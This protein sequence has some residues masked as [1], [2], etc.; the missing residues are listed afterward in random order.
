MN[1]ERVNWGNEEIN[2]KEGNN[3]KMEDRRNWNE[4]KQN[5]DQL[6]QITYMQCHKLGNIPCEEWWMG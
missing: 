4:T 5:D 2:R 3:E 1:V 6:K